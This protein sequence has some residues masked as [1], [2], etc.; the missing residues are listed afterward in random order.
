V[1]RVFAWAGLGV[2][3][4]I[5]LLEGRLH[6]GAD[7]SVAD[8]IAI[9]RERVWGPLR[10]VNTYH[11][12][13][14]ITRERVEPQFET[15]VDGTWSPQHLRHKPGD[16]ASAPDFVAPHEPR[17]DFQLWFYAF[18]WQRRRPEWVENLVQRLCYAPA[19][20]QSLF[21]VPL[22]VAP[23]AVRLRYFE[24]HF[25]TP[26]ERRAGG[27]YWRRILLGTSPEVSCDR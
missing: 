5:S 23:T 17:V 4:A 27:E 21:R 24:Y 11:L 16:P 3:T 1:R 8:A 22:P 14:A 18:K 9:A 6:F 20:V 15:L 10:V 7:D 12:F 19:A 13:A 25:T 2:Y 26:S